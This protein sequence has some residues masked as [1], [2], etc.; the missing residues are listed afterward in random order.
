MYFNFPSQLNLLQNII[1]FCF[2]TEAVITRLR[3]GHTKANKSHILSRG[4]PVACYHCG[5]RL[6]IDHKLLE[7]A[8]LQECRD[9]YYTV[10]S[11][12]TLFEKI[13]ETCI[14]KSLREAGFFYLICC[15]LLTSISP[16]TWTIWSDFC[17]IC[18]ENESNSNTFTCVGRLICPEGR[19]LSLNKSYQTNL[20]SVFIRLF[21]FVCHA[22]ENYEPMCYLLQANTYTRCYTKPHTCDISGDCSSSLCGIL[23]RHPQFV[24]E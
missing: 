1:L 17:V 7:C 23:L 20:T 13:P 3:I 24:F 12:N 19:V 8:V 18:L 14:V 2:G 16:E 21:Q 11:L 4:P 9:E 5:R 10:D 6:T 15:K 22:V